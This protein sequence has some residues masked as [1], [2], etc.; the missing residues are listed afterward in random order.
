L[1]RRG[2]ECLSRRERCE[3]GVGSALSSCYRF[4]WCP[5]VTLHEHFLSG[6]DQVFGF[7]AEIEPSRDCLASFHGWA[8]GDCRYPSLQMLQSLDTHTGPFVSVHPTPIGDVRDRV[9]SGEVLV[10][11]KLVIK[12]LEE[13]SAFPLIAIDGELELL[14]RVTVED[15][16]LSHHR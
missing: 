3:P 10:I 7:G 2:P 15:I 11:L 14:R 13:S 1:L 9:V 4:S 5:P 6:L 12:H 8:G 16:S